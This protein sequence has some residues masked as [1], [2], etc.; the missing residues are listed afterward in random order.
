MLNNIEITK[1]YHGENL[2]SG[3]DLRRYLIVIDIQQDLFTFCQTMKLTLVDNTKTL[4]KLL[5]HGDKVTLEYKDTYF[6]ERYL[7]MYIYNVHEINKNNNSII[8]VNLC[9]KILLSRPMI[10]KQYNDSSLVEITKNIMTDFIN[11]D[12]DL[13]DIGDN[14]NTNV[15]TLTFNNINPLSAIS[16]ICSEFPD[17]DNNFAL[18]FFQNHDIDKENKQNRYNLC[19]LFTLYKQKP[20]ATYRLMGYKTVNSVDDNDKKL[21]DIIDYRIIHA[22]NTFAMDNSSVRGEVVNTLDLFNHKYAVNNGSSNDYES[23]INLNKN[24]IYQ[25][26]NQSNNIK[27][28]VIVDNDKGKDNTFRHESIGKRK[29]IISKLVHGKKIIAEIAPNNLLSVGMVLNIES[30]ISSVN[31]STQDNQYKTKENVLSGKYIITAIRQK[32]TGLSMR[33][34]IELSS[35]SREYL[36]DE[37]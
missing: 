18:L 30:F 25:N 8:I 36:D 31:E 37:E 27:R 5:R 35:D 32:M 21:F 28:L 19:S 20:I 6:K 16:K 9:D 33:M 12:T 15:K 3:F 13:L 17:T 22:S 4:I 29:N 7:E 24:D 14:I 23:N 26:L 1:F 10:S 2:N 11:V 34:S